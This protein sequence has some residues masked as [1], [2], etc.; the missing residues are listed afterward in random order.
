[1]QPEGGEAGGY[2]TGMCLEN[3]DMRPQMACKCNLQIWY[4]RPQM[5]CKCNLQMYPHCASNLHMPLTNMQVTV[6]FYMHVSLLLP[7]LIPL[8][9]RYNMFSSCRDKDSAFII[10]PAACLTSTLLETEM[11]ANDCSRDQQL[12]VPS[13]AR[14]SSR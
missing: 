6:L 5:A 2:E 7:T 3:I 12:N 4:L 10:R 1:M 11:D 13:E 9:V 14:R 8:S